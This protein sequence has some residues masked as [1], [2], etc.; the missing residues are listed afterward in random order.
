M[1]SLK[2]SLKALGLSFEFYNVNFRGKSKAMS[3]S[4]ERAFLVVRND[5]HYKHSNWQL[6]IIVIRGSRNR[7]I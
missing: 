5:K 4:E 6:E 3:V 1:V 2:T 7:S